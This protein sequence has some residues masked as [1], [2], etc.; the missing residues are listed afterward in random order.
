MSNSTD[1]GPDT[2]GLTKLGILAGRGTLP[3]AVAERAR[4]RG[5]EVLVL[6]LR[7]QGDPAVY[8]DDFPTEVV[9]IGAAGTAMEI[10]RREG[11]R[12]LVFV[13]GVR[14]PSLA[15]LRPD[16]T[17]LRI[18][19]GRLLSLGDDGL[20][21]RIIAHLE[22]HEGF[23]IHPIDA[24]LDDLRPESGT[25]GRVEP[26]ADAMGDIQRGQALLAALS[27]EDVGQSVAIQNGL[28]LG[29]EAIEG[30]DALIA[31][32]GALK[33]EGRGP[34]LVKMS[35]HGQTER[36]DL[37]TIGPET[38]HNAV[39]AG[40]S[41]IALEAGRSLLVERDAAREAADAAGLFLIAVPGIDREPR[42]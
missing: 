10:L 25:L 5:I 1:P 16:A 37:P 15:E 3:R 22:A 2:T 32:C 24:I 29:I 36:A 12:D 34:V 41:G 39:Q 4:D 35:K 30:T 19:G 27:A 9:R 20:L 26:C 8:R 13:G 17:A 23:R 6:V 40:F 33:R 28:V 14:R 11:I 18:L 31:R 42:A 21:R 7:D 38:V